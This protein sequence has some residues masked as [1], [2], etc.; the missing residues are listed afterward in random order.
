MKVHE[1]IKALQNCGSD[2]EV[3]TPTGTI[4]HV[5]NGDEEYPTVL[6]TEDPAMTQ[7]EI[8]HEARVYP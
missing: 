3:I 5:S 8:E 4:A 1:L 7:E 2:Y 6:L